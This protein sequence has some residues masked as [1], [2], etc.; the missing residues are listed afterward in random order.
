MSSHIRRPCDNCGGE[1]F[2][3]VTSREIKTALMSAVV[4]RANHTMIPDVAAMV[5][6]Y[7][8]EECSMLRFFLCGPDDPA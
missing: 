7:V 3:C 8:C 6:V 1:S 2:V 5:D 4:Q